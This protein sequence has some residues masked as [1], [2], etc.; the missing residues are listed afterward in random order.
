MT[1]RLDD[2]YDCFPCYHIQSLHTLAIF[3]PTNYLHSW[4]GQFVV[5]QKQLEQICRTETISVCCGSFEL[6]RKKLPSANA[7]GDFAHKIAVHD[8]CNQLDTVCSVIPYVTFSDEIRL[9]RMFVCHTPAGWEEKQT[10]LQPETVAALAEVVLKPNT[11]C[12]RKLKVQACAE[13]LVYSPTW[14]CGHS[15]ELQACF[16]VRELLPELVP[17]LQ[18]LEMATAM[19]VKRKFCVALS[20]N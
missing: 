7:L 18:Q 14:H 1:Y 9:C 10:R 15:E 19:E 13:G 16:T 4:S 20:P 2:V 11:S 8:P 5:E 17:L 12:G 3:S 6:L